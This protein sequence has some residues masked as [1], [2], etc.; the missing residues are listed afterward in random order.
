[1]A[2]DGWPRAGG[3]LI[4]QAC[5]G[6]RPGE[7]LGV[8]RDDLVPGRR[9]LHNGNA[10]VALGKRT[11][12]KSGRPQFVVVHADE[13]T[14]AMALISAFAATT[15]HG[16]GLSSIDYAQ[17]KRCLDNATRALGLA[18]IG[19]TPHSPRAGWATRLRLGG[20][21][22]QEIQERGR[23][24]SASALRIYLDAVAASTT[25]LHRTHFLIEFATYVE[26]DF[27]GRFPWWR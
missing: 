2:M 19:F 4:L 22:F 7:L 11:G 24:Q 14:T 23:W 13:D 20:M 21:P 27:A 1:M 5:L 17:Y 9:G 16:A 8:R 3:L 12:T 6:L 25:L 18:D 26:N 15:P 10:V